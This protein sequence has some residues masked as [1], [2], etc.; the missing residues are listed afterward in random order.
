MR[1]GKAL[2]IIC[3]LMGAWNLFS[4]L[5]L[6]II[7]VAMS[8]DEDDPIMLIVLG[9]IAVSLLA[10]GAALL[11]V[12]RLRKSLDEA[13]Y[14][15]TTATAT[16][17]A[18]TIVSRQTIAMAP[19]AT[20]SPATVAPAPVPAPVNER[21]TPSAQADPRGDAE[22]VASLVNRSDDVF[23]TLKDLV[24]HEQ[25]TPGRRRH[26]AEMLQA[27]GLLEWDDAPRCEAGRLTRNH[28]FWIRLGADDLTDEEYDRL[29]SIEA[30][31]SVNQD[32]DSPTCMASDIDGACGEASGLL[33]RLVS[34]DIR[35]YDLAASIGTAYPDTPFDETPG[36]WL[37]RASF[38]SA[39]ECSVTPFRVVY[40]QRSNVA[41]GLM[42]V[43]VE[44]PRPRCMAIFS[45]QEADQVAIARGYALRLA[46]LLAKQALSLSH[47]VSTVVVN[48]HERGSD[49]TILSVA[50][51]DELLQRL[52]PFLTSYDMAANG[53]PSDEAIHVRF[54]ERGW[55][56][57]V[58]AHLTLDD[59][60]LS[61]GRFVYPELV[62]RATSAQLA[63]I[64]GA[65]KVSDLGINENAGRIAAWDELSATPWENTEEAVSRLREKLLS[66]SDITVVEACNRT[67]EALVSGTEDAGNLEGLANL[68]IRGTS[69]EQAVRRANAALDDSEGPDNPEEAVRVLSEALRPIESVGA[70]LDDQDTV[71]RYFGS[72]AERIC[73]ELEINDRRRDVRLVP[74][75]YYNALANI[76]IAYDELEQYDDAM[77]YADEMI[78]IAPASI[79]AAMRKV[80]ALEHQS[81]IYEAA[82]LIKSVLRLASTPRDAAICH[83]R[84]AFMEWKLGREDLAVA[85]YQ[86]SLTW[87]TDMFSQAREELDDLLSSNASLHRLSD[88]EVSTL[89]A[90]EGIPLGCTEA[91]RR[92]TLAAATLCTDEGVFWAARS[93]VGILFGIESDDVMMGVY[94][95]LTPA[96]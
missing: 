35:P 38:A 28:H 46:A 3:T 69:L 31:L 2:N 94:R 78:R 12:P 77:R 55:L 30:A 57:P 24:R 32:L 54:D 92:R 67:I 91:D 82:D 49:D 27:T 89:L 79:H 72:V 52:M 96:S 86:R 13:T 65:R 6:G 16:A 17:P 75:A 21:L 18:E 95:S 68:F 71:Y 93:L 26:L 20:N 83:Y 4:G 25:A 36:E 73:F 9:G 63:A 66:A 81:R 40:D 11:A 50:F 48:C 74:D 56:Q 51:T 87:D 7:A 8:I 58:E 47:K 33:Q 37:V 29:V 80:R 43:S 22:E 59:P 14:G 45:T 42:V 5:I 85:C 53:F 64:T 23:A 10:G 76:S 15:P 61:A 39:A 19:Q 60:R 34:Q 1:K 84:L 41:E 44:V 62:D 88:D 70:Y 90:N